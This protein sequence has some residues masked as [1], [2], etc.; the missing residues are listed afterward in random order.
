MQYSSSSGSFKTTFTMTQPI[1]T[2]SYTIKATTDTHLTRL[3]PGIQNITAGQNN[4]LPN[5][6]FIAGD[7]INDNKLDI[8]DYNTLIGCYSDL[9]AA[10]SCNDTQKTAS[11]LNDDGA[12]NQFDYNL[13]LREIAI[14]P[15]Q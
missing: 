10:T 14:Q 7:I 6:T 12:V 8:L 11:D 4:E 13:L 15:G 5:A 3:V 9:A 1:T 2:G